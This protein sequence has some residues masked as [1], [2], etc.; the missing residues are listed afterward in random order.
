MNK[1]R[2]RTFSSSSSFG[3]VSRRALITA[4]AVAALFAVSA[5]VV[6]HA[7]AE[8]MPGQSI[9][10]AR[11]LLS[12][13]EGWKSEHADGCPTISQLVEDGKLDDADL[14]DDAWGNRFRIVCDG[15]ST[16][17]RSAGPDRRVGTKDDM[18]VSHGS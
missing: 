3:K 9:D 10:A 16:S 18:N 2:A 12:A 5:A 8:E 1:P 14:T 6:A 11:Q 7:G 17:V 4:G 15:A 13:A